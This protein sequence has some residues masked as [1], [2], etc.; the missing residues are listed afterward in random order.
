MKQPVIFAAFFL[1]LAWRSRN[2]RLTT[3]KMRAKLGAST[4]FTNVV[5]INLSREASVFSTGF[6]M[7]AMIG[8]TSCWISG[9]LTTLPTSSSACCA[10]D[11]TC[12]LINDALRVGS[13]GVCLDHKVWGR[14][15]TFGWV[16]DN[17]SDNL[18][19]IVGRAE[20]NWRGAQCDMAP[21][22]CTLLCFVFQ[23]LSPKPFITDG[24]TNFTP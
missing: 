20:L 7:A 13:K 16:S 3:G 1:T 12:A 14:K 11:W 19:T 22:S 18:G 4:L 9:F 5:S 17:D 6:V 2:P 15:R 8:S 10:A 21:R 23:C 24:S